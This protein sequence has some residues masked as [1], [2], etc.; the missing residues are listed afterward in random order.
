MA[1]NLPFEK[2]HGNSIHYR[3]D[4]TLGRCAVELMDFITNKT[5]QNLYCTTNDIETAFITIDKFGKEKSTYGDLSRSTAKKQLEAAGYIVCDRLR[6]RNNAKGWRA[7]KEYRDV[8]EIPG[9]VYASPYRFYPQQPIN[10]DFLYVFKR[11]RDSIYKIGVTGN[12]RSRAMAVACNCGSHLE[13]VAHLDTDEAYIIE[14]ELHER[15]NH[16][17][18]PGEWFELDDNDL[19]RIRTFLSDVENGSF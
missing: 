14:Q 7:V 8:N 1:I 9:C 6:D 19:A 2:A 12:L 10:K 4:P 11:I 17:R 5:K 18:L 16:K 13:L 3:Q 15:F